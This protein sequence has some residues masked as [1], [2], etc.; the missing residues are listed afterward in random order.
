M[1][2]NTIIIYAILGVQY[3]Y[4]KQRIRTLVHLTYLMI[5]LYF[6]VVLKQAFQES[7]P[8]WYHTSI[9][10]IEWFCPTDF[11]NPSGH[12]FIAFS[13]YEPL[14]SDFIGTGKRKVFLF[15]WAVVGVLVMISR[16]FLGA[17]S[18]DQVV[19]GSLIGLSF[20]V[21]YRFWLQQFLYDTFR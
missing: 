11:G 1:F 2:G 21:I 14:L 3:I 17:H 13:M 20:L 16:M 15:I 18:L 9:N 7:R 4:V 5:G 12:S 8:F 10:I 6:M 19:F